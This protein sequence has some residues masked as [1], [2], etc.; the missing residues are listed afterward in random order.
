MPNAP[1]AI[2]SRTLSEWRP[3]GAVD[4][5]AITFPCHLPTH[6]VCCVL[7]PANGG[8]LV[9]HQLRRYGCQ[10]LG[11][12]GQDRGRVEETFVEAERVTFRAVFAVREF[13]AMWAAEAL[14]QAGDQLARVAL[15]VLVYTDTRSAALAGL[16]Y[17]LTW[18]PSFLGG[19][20]LSGLADRFP[21][22]NI[23]VAADLARAVLIALVAL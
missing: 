10:E 23:M 20:F 1:A 4:G 14:S 12:R 19:V 5:D 6:P 21:R 16:T 8:L 2:G 13:R 15:A 11:G 3:P 17:A 9:R 7:S 22:R 18:A